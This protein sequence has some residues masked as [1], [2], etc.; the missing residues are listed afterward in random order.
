MQNPNQPFNQSN[1][2]DYSSAP[3]PVAQSSG[4]VRL[5][6]LRKTYAL[7]FAGIICCLLVGAATLRVPALFGISA[8]LN[9]LIALLL[10]V[11]LS[12]G[13]QAVSRM[14]GLNYA[15]LFTFTGFLG[16]IFAPMLAIYELQ[17]P[18]ILAQ[19]AV[20]TTITFSA[21]T[22]Y[23]FVS[24]KDFSFMGGLLFVGLIGLILGGLANAFLI[25]S[26]VASYLMAWFTLLLFS[27]YVLYD[28]SNIMQRY[29]SRGYCSAA[30]SLFLD[31][32]NMFLAI[33]RILSGSRR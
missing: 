18:G 9:P 29:D 33:L 1:P 10:I 17:Q 19:A 2:F 32:F 16:F 22:A 20:L 23:V 3:V 11:G 15:A 7:F 21:L 6:F 24:K 4:E 13:A 28:T 25:H 30:L 31:F 12:Y 26:P 8:S 14:E 5:E 27:G